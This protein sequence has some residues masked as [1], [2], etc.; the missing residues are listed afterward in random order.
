MADAKASSPSKERK[1]SIL[2]LANFGTVSDCFLGICSLQSSSAKPIKV[3]MDFASSRSQHILY[4]ISSV[5]TL[6][7][8]PAVSDYSRNPAFPVS[9][10]PTSLLRRILA[11]YSFKARCYEKVRLYN[12][13]MSQ[14]LRY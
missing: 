11:S 5:F 12:Y 13:T 1:H 2:P 14:N 6:I 4:W 7:M 9:S 8:I 10:D 3:V